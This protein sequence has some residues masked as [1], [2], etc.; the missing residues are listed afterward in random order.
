M[1]SAHTLLNQQLTAVKKVRKLTQGI[2]KIEWVKIRERN[3]ALD[4]VVFALACFT[5]LT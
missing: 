4:L 2:Q 1:F 3:E 5:M